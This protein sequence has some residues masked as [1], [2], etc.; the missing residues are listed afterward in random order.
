M[1]SGDNGSGFTIE[2]GEKGVYK[3][4]LFGIVSVGLIDD[5]TGTTCKTNTYT[6]YTDVS[7]HSKFILPI[8][9]DY[10]K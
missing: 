8:L 1:C 9:S 6:F 10:A 2:V 7:K 5:V 3:W 4:Y